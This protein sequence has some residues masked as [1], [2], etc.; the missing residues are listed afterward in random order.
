MF[1][2]TMTLQLRARGYHHF[3]ANADRILLTAWNT[4]HARKQ[5]LVV[6]EIICG[7]RY[8]GYKRRTGFNA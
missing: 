8:V 2:N 6:A 4:L 1:V 7:A 5:A 3:E